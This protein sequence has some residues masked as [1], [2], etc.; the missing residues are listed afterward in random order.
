MKPI[1]SKFEY[2]DERDEDLFCTFRLLIEETSHIKLRDIYIQLVDMPA[3]RFWVS[4]ERAA[5]VISDMFKGKSLK[6]MRPNK[7]EMFQ[8][9]FRRARELREKYPNKSIAEIAFDVVRQQ[10]PKFYITP[11]SARILI[12]KAKEK[13]K[14]RKFKHQPLSSQPS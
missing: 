11:S 9:I 1:G 12:Y 6:G 2:E 14:Q 7:K 8:E 4:E 13:W 5:I 10:A 3:Q